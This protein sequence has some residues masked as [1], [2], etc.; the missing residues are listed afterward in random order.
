VV[1]LYEGNVFPGKIIN[2]DGENVYFFVMVKS[3]KSC[4][5]PEKSD[6]LEYEWSDALGGI[7]PPELVSKRDFHSI[8]ELPTF[9]VRTVSWWVIVFFIFFL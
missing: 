5:W 4:K 6:T 2:F 7:D 1:F 3:L 8:P 9:F